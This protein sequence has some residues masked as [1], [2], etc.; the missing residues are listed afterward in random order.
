[1]V[2]SWLKDAFLQARRT[3]KHVARGTY[4]RTLLALSAQR[5][6]CAG[7]SVRMV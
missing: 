7:M 3:G 5:A 6:A 4:R 2:T 1:M